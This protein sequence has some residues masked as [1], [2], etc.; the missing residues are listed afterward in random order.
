MLR[1]GYQG[2]SGQTSSSSHTF[3][4]ERVTEEGEVV[5]ESLDLEEVE[6]AFSKM[7]RA[8]GVSQ[9]QEV[10][11]RFGSQ[12]ATAHLLDHQQLKA[13]QEVLLLTNQKERLVAEW[14]EVKLLGQD[15]QQAVTE[16][17]EDMDLDIEFAVEKAGKNKARI[18]GIEATQNK[19]RRSLHKLSLSLTGEQRSQAQPE[20]LIEILR[21][22]LEPL[23]AR[24]GRGQLGVL[25]KQ[26]EREGFQPSVWDVQEA[27][28]GEPRK[29]EDEEAVEDEEEIPTR[30]SLLRSSQAL[31]G[32]RIGFK[33]K[34]QTRK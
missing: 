28:I 9:V 16:R 26:M 2:M 4:I 11:Q 1:S 7:K 34:G 20:E 17:I 8:A 27:D 10:I 3:S 5:S 19:I 13:K 15:E 32:S 22:E 6:E 23:L 29:R 21:S 25:Q 24:V 14:D 30:A 33:G 12:R 18:V 31:V